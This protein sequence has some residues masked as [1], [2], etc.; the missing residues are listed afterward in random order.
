MDLFNN[1]N[2]KLGKS[3]QCEPPATVFLFEKVELSVNY[4]I[5]NNTKT[6][7]KSKTTK[8]FTIR[9]QLSNINKDTGYAKADCTEH[10]RYIIYKNKM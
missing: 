10:S 2:Q 7:Q 1:Y 3:Y 4:L 9:S 6:I 8:K 5:P